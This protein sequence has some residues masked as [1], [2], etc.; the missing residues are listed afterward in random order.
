MRVAVAR[1]AN[2]TWVFVDGQVA[3]TRNPRSCGQPTKEPRR[4]EVM[5]PMPA[6]VVSIHAAAGDSVT[7]GQ[8][9][10]EAMK[11]ELPIKAPRN[12]IV[13]GSLREGRPGATRR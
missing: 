9:V 2:A 11:M 12:G 10:L 5:S 13:K 8:I 7:E 1:D 6:T 3:R 4:N